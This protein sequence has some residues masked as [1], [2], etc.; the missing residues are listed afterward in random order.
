MSSEKE[1]EHLA[2]KA[3]EEGD[4]PPAYE[5][6]EPSSA[7]EIVSPPPPAAAGE[8]SKAAMRPT[9]DAPFN[10]PEDGPLPTYSEASSSKQPPIAIPQESPTPTA[11][12]LNA[13]PPALL[14]HGITQ[15]AWSS[16]LDTMS[17]FLTAKVG[18]RAINHAGDIA[19]KV[20]QRPTSY[21]K[22][23]VSHTKSVGKNIGDNAKR[24]NIIGAAFGVIGGAISIPVGA[25]LG[26]V[27]T[28]VSLPAHTI[29]AVTRKPKTPAERAVA[30]VTVANK[31]WFNKRGLH[32][33]LVNTEQLSEVLGVSVKAVLEASTG[34]KSGGA[35][36]QLSALRE[37]IAHLEIQGPGVIDLAD[38]T[39]WLVVVRIEATPEHRE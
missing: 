15:E 2:N 28:V 10:F 3:P 18:E 16:F 38:A 12:F 7:R 13:Y 17:A 20:G 25:A 21:V 24:G 31:D 23:V 6:G 30:Y 22:N 35:E 9:A 19:K 34:D 33:S 4:A 8:S 1:R 32:A 11:P 14:S 5:T 26:A 39:T 37:H 27:G 29:A 36:G